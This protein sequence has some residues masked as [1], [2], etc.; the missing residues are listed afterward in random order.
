MPTKLQDVTMGGNLLQFAQGS[1]RFNCY[2]YSVAHIKTSITKAGDCMIAFNIRGYMYGPNP[3]DTDVA[4][5]CYAAVSYVYGVSIYQRSWSGW[6]IG[7][8]Y[9]SDN[10]V[11][12]YVD[13]MSTYGGFALNWINTS[14][15]PWGT[16]VTTL[17]WTKTNST[18]P[19]F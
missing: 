18:S 19:A 6:S 5:Y 15:I 2:G 4:F 13:G 8:Y 11:C 12:F 16:T 10:Y 3:V 14:L 1:T 7:M 17:D 9:S